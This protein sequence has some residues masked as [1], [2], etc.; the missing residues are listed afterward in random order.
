VNQDGKY[1]I[2]Y[3]S[4][5]KAGNVEA[6]KSI[7]FNL[8]STAPVILVSGL[9][10]GMSYNDSG[11]LTPQPTI[12]DNLSGVDMTKTA[13]ML[14]GQNV[15]Q[16]VAIPLYTLP[17]GS[18]AF[19]VTA[20]DAAGNAQSVTVTFWT[21]ADLDSLKA[22]VTRFTDNKG[23]DNAGISKSLQKRLAQGELGEFVQLVR[24]QTGKHITNA[25]AKYLMRDAQAFLDYLKAKVNQFTSD[26]SINRA[27]L[28]KDLLEALNE[29][30]VKDFAE[31]VQEE[32]GKHISQDA[33]ISLLQGLQSLLAESKD[34]N[35]ESG[36]KQQASEK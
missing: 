13:A 36:N 9:T 3:R 21:Y 30:N 20:N 1:T 15:Q 19:T 4:V 34:N 10:D 2:S 7:G 32:S 5:D 14:D 27:D 31:K 23:I 22:L 18:H 8:D 16:G 11:D 26:K 29:G 12:T 35:T 24:V 6:A 33:A 28:A 17:L 25:A